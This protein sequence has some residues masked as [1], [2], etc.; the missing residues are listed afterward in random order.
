MTTGPGNCE[1]KRAPEVILAEA[2]K[3]DLGVSVDPQALRVFI[4]WRWDRLHRL[5]HKIH[6]AA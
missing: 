1:D 2:I 3:N 4:R 6:E 5:A